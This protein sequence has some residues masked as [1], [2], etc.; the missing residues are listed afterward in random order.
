MKRTME[1]V[2]ESERWGCLR[3]SIVLIELNKIFVEVCHDSLFAQRHEQNHFYA[4]KRL[5]ASSTL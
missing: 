3:K 1:L 2:F 5:Q 4:E